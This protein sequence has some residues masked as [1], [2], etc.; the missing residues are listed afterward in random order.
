MIP[1]Y[2]VT[3]GKMLSRWRLK[4]KYVHQLKEPVKVD[5]VHI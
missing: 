4:E 1:V 3:E 2:K 5:L